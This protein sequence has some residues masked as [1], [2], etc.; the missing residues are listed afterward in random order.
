MKT[1]CESWLQLVLW[2]KHE[3]RKQAPN[4]HVQHDDNQGRVV[5]IV[6]KAC[7]L[8]KKNYF[9]FFRDFSH[10]AWGHNNKKMSMVALFSINAIDQG[11]ALKAAFLYA[12]KSNLLFRMIDQILHARMT[13]STSSC[14][15][16]NSIK[17]CHSI[18]KIFI[19]SHMQHLEVE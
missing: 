18:L 6:S 17:K 2:Q 19:E 15:A 4:T 1:E 11:F 8:S 5:L 9:A 16:N 3:H 10:H 13:C 12:T 14:C 7:M